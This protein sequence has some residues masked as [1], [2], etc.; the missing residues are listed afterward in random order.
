MAD[1]TIQAL[2]TLTPAKQDL[3]LAVDQSDSYGAKKLT[4]EALMNFVLGNS[5][6][7]DIS[8][9]RLRLQNSLNANGK[10]I[11]G[12]A[13]GEQP[14]DAVNYGTVSHLVEQLTE[15]S[16]DAP[17]IEEYGSHL[18]VSTTAIDAPSG[19][20]YL[21]Y[22]CVDQLASTELTVSGG[23]VVSGT[24]T[25]YCEGSVANVANIL[26]TAGLVGRYLHVAVR[27][28]NSQ[29][30]SPISATKHHLLSTGIFE[31]V[32]SDSMVVPPPT[33]LS[34]VAD[35]NLLV[36]SASPGADVPPGTRYC[37]EIVMSNDNDYDVV[38]SE[39]NLIRLASY[40]PDFAYEIPVSASKY[41]YAHVRVLAVAPNGAQ[42]AT[43]TVSAGYT[44]YSGNIL[45]DALLGAIATAVADCLQTAGG[46]AL[47][48]K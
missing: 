15:V 5:A 8:N 44:Y 16:P 34:V 10:K 31:D 7:F 23:A 47:V 3:I 39:Y 13:A 32:F 1:S 11:T 43:K 14:G 24:G 29:H 28:R 4:L 38:G 35:D 33:E 9:G 42:G 19:G 36:I 40:A 27:Y 37:A 45:D 17:T 22:W 12:L 46:E 20:S 48:K 30:V 26:K 18:R 2:Q 25:V 6:A 41:T 21:F